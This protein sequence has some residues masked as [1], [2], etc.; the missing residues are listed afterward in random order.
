M[1]KGDDDLSN[2]EISS[3]VNHEGKPFCT[4]VC[5][6]MSKRLIIG[7]LDPDE[8]RRMALQWL[9]TAEAADQDAAVLRVMRK[10]NLP[11]DLAAVIVA[12]LRDSRSD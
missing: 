10:M 4:I 9:E 12:E 3:G 5:Q 2:V 8:V 6:T 7:Q 1:N 11:D